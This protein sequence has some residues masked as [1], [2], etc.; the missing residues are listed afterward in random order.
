MNTPTITPDTVIDVWVK[1]HKITI[2]DQ[3]S[4]ETLFDHKFFIVGC[5]KSETIENA[6]KR[7]LN[8]LQI[9]PN[10]KLRYVRVTGHSMYITEI[11]KNIPVGVIEKLREKE[12]KIYTLVLVP[13][14]PI[15]ITNVT[16]PL[17]WEVVPKLVHDDDLRTIRDSEFRVYEE[18]DKEVYDSTVPEDMKQSEFKDYQRLSVHDSELVLKKCKKV[19]RDSNGT[20]FSI[21]TKF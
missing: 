7:H 19:M 12:E 11:D 16:S 13:S 14:P 6:I 4:I 18:E 2:Y 5:F 21:G 8:L 17:L 3:K 10:R 9:E 15:I 1:I 20:D